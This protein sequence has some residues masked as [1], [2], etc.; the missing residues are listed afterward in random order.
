MKILLIYLAAVNLLAFVLMAADKSKARNNRWR[1]SERT[2]ILTA[3]AGGSVGALLGMLAFRHKTRHPKFTVG[4]PV[5]LILQL[6]LAAAIWYM[7]IRR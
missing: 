2:L 3:A 6:A 7:V 1:I 5:I 4:I